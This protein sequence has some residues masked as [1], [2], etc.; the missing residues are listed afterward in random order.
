MR[1]LLYQLLLLCHTAAVAQTAKSRDL[2][3]P[4][5]PQ[6]PKV[7]TLHGEKRVD[8]YFW[9]R[10]KT[11]PAVIRYLKAEN[12]Y[13]E[14]K[15]KSTKTLQAKLFR[16]MRSHIKETD[17]S[18]PQ[19]HDGYYYYTR[20]QKGKQYSI[21][22][23]RRGSLESPEEVILDLNRLARGKEF[24]SLGAINT[25]DDGNLLAYSTDI[26]GFRE[27]TLE[28]KDL[29][30][31]RLLPFRREHVSDVEWTDD[32]RTLFYTTE[33]SA[34][35]SYRLYRHRLGQKG[36]DVLVHEE[37]DER[38]DL[39]IQRSRSRAWLFLTIA[40]HTTSEVRFLASA[41]PESNWTLIAPREQDHEYDVDHHGDFF[42][43]RSNQTGRN[44]ALFRTPITKPGRL[45]W[46]VV[47]PHRAEVMLE[48]VDF[49]EDFYV[50][51]ELENAQ[52]QLRVTDLATGK[53]HRIPFAE[54]AYTAS[55]LSNPEFRTKTLRYLYESFTTPPS[56]YDYAVAGK[57][58]V[59]MKQTEVPGGFI[60]TNYISERL[61]ATASD[62]T[63]V[64]LS[65]VYRR[66]VRRDGQAP[67]LLTG[68]GAYGLPN[69]PQF[70]SVRLSL[71]DR[72]VVVAVAHIRGGGDLGKAWHDAGRMRQK[73]NTFT[74]FIACAEHL[75]QKKYTSSDRLAI[76]GGSAGGLLIGGVL[77]LRPDLFR[78]AILD[79]PFVDVVNTMLD[80]SLPLTVGE[81]EEWGNPKD[82]GDY[83][84]LKSYCPYTNL[85]AASYPAILINT[86]LNDSQ[87]MYWEPAKYTAKLRTL[88]TGPYPPL[89]RINMAAGHGGASG[90]YDNLKESAFDQAFLLQQWGIKK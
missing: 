56:V 74:D 40:S 1:L 2:E 5:A 24:F 29:R 79:V 78:T 61:T 62:G 21:Y 89:L 46:K 69:L 8:P 11:N 18:V 80:E 41:T 9:L 37:K 39:G 75:I 49:F 84:Y 44:F 26:T 87:V 22:C 81:F 47:V 53:S 54:E 15:M 34:K 65:V 57:K 59:I 58:S 10:E 55:L 38:F 25:S 4:V 85:R 36:P 20:S 27:Y 72:G 6:H 90:R 86:S 66:G 52:S 63:K 71:L 19:L 77:N 32:N 14:A 7:S 88:N 13:T 35:R 31:G 48:E 70:S 17:L 67:L 23:R 12:R 45:N 16:E 68:Y 73:R 50:L 28:I 30:T 33:D 3:P 43:I 51:S 82:P 64:P 76:Q 60:S 83:A 42:Y